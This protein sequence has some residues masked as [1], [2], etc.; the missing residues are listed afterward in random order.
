MIAKVKQSEIFF[1]F[2]SRRENG[3]F[4]DDAYTGLTNIMP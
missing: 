2:Q 4:T 3:N 1:E